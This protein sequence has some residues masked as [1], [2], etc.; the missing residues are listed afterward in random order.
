MCIC[1]PVRLSVCLYVCPSGFT[2]MCKEVEPSA[3]MA[4]LNDLYSRYDQMLDE[5][6]V[7]KVET[8]GD[9]YFVAG[10]LIQEDEDGMTAVRDNQTDPLHAQKVFEFARVSLSVLGV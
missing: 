2:P 3:V 7:F 10:G 5:Y 8:I 1:P 4:M 9:C 6:G